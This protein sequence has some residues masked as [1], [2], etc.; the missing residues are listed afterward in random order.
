[1]SKNLSILFLL[2][3]IALFGG[4]MYVAQ[5]AALGEEALS[6]IESIIPQS[7]TPRFGP[8]RRS[9][10][11]QATDK[12]EGGIQRKIGEESAKVAQAEALAQGLKG[13][14]VVLF[15]LGAFFLVRKKR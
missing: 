5:Q 12:M 2:L 11:E 9:L 13:V 4:G 7:R 15:A 10:S 8:A 1:M 14:G 3:G 6:K